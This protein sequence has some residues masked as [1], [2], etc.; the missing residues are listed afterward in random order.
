MEADPARRTRKIRCSSRK[1]S[2]EENILIISFA[3]PYAEK[4]KNR[5]QAKKIGALSNRFGVCA[6]MMSLFE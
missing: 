6:S 4:R 1:L 3:P 2:M 5:S